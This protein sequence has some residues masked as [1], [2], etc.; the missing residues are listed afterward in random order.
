MIYKNEFE[1]ILAT[2]KTWSNHNKN[3]NNKRLNFQWINK[4]RDK[5]NDT[6]NTDNFQLQSFLRRFRDDHS[7]AA[8]FGNY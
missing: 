2:T 8:E 4:N 6:N 7:T 5:F 3:L 1:P